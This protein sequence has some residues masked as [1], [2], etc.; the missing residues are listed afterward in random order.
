MSR[1]PLPEFLRH[2]TRRQEQAVR[3]LRLAAADL[4]G[5]HPGPAFYWRV[6]QYLRLLRPSDGP[7][8]YQ[9]GWLKELAALAAI[10]PYNAYRAAVFCR[11]FS[12]DQAAHLEEAGVPWAHVALLCGVKD[13]QPRQE[14]LHGVLVE[15][16]SYSRLAAEKRAGVPR[17]KEGGQR[18][19]HLSEQER[20]RRLL[21]HAE[22]CLNLSSLQI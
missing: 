19:H 14:L 6:G 9:T 10:S 8:R 20:L 7:T 22:Q 18:P 2:L 1:E 21:R 3:G 5:R 17:A 16:W 11:M 13:D 4:P 15:G 12:R